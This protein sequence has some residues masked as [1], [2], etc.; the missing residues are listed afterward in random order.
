[1]SNKTTIFAVLAGL[2]AGAALG[3]WFA[4][5]KNDKLR[6]KIGKAL[7]SVS[8]EIKEKLIN[9]F[10]EIK[11]KAGDL[12]S[13]G[14]NLKDQIMHSLTDMKEDSKQKVM[15]FIDKTHAEASREVNKAHDNSKQAVKQL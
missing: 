11:M 1:M 9:E 5:E 10:D 8:D 7:N 15:D 3:Y 14:A 13:K 6:K 2:G 4:S 12:K